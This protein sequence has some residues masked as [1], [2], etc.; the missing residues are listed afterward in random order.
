M[1][2]S[3]AVKFKDTLMESNKFAVKLLGHLAT[4]DKSTVIGSNMCRI[5][6][7]LGDTPLSVSNVKKTLKYCVNEEEKWRSSFILDLLKV[8]YGDKVLSGIDNKEVETLL[9]YLCCS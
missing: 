6:R 1:L 4:R 3:R 2:A 5:M 8:R 7:E 9:E